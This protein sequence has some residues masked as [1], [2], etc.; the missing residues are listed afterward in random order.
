MPMLLAAS[1]GGPYVASN[2]PQW[3]SDVKSGAAAASSAPTA[4]AGPAPASPIAPV[5]DPFAAP[6]AIASTPVAPTPAAATP[7]PPTPAQQQATA[8]PQGP[9]ATLYPTQTPLEGTPTYGLAEVFNFNVTKDWVY[10]RWARK[11]T[12][13]AELDLFGIRVPLVTGTQLYDVAGSL[14][15]FFGADGRVRRISFRGQTGDTS[16]LVALVTQRYG[17]QAQPTVVA[18]EQ[19]FQLRNGDEL[20]SEL[21]TQPSPILW[22]SSPHSS[23]RV[24]LELQ[25]PAAA[26]PLASSTLAATLPA[27]SAA[28]SAPPTS[29]GAT[30][31]AT[32]TPPTTAAAEA[33]TEKPAADAEKL[34]WKA[35]F[36]RSRMSKAQIENLDQ[37]NLYQW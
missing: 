34:G 33:P 23:F 17:L 6:A 11:S 35:F 25:D 2:A 20:I 24:E 1:V 29:P 4:A 14:T 21:H 27:N 30:P 12:A 26:R 19:L 8:P 36:P 16:Q 10:Q 7:P 32:S 3:V 9:G 28:A 15:Y 18:G 37:G 31:V 13:L 22:S 5:S